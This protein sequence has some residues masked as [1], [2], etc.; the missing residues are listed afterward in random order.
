MLIS[1]LSFSTWKDK[2]LWM[3]YK[4]LLL[5]HKNSIPHTK[6]SYEV[7]MATYIKLHL[8]VSPTVLFRSWLDFSRD[9][10]IVYNFFLNCLEVKDGYLQSL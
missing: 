2:K 8:E 9:D 4:R 10:E 7:G 5:S 3:T 6:V 1:M